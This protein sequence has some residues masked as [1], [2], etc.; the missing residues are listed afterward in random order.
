MSLPNFLL[1]NMQIINHRL[2][3]GIDS[4]DLLHEIYNNIR[5]LP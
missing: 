1:D 5:D 3:T 2:Y 4:D